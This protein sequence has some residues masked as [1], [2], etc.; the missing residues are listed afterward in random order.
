[1]TEPAVRR[2]AAATPPADALPDGPAA[3]STADSS[4]GRPQGQVP[5]PVLGVVLKG[6]PRLS[7][8]FIAQ[9]LLALQQRGFRLR[10]ISLR[11]PTDRKRH[12]IHD[13]ITAPVCYLPEYLYQ[14]ALRVLAGWRRARRLPGYRAAWRAFLKDLRRDLTPNRARR[15]GQACV[16]AAEL[17]AEVERLYAH[18]LHTPASVARYTSLMRG[19]PW[20]VSAHAK[21]IWTIPDWE[22]REKL[23]EADWL[24]TCTAYGARHLRDLA[25]EPGRVTLLYHGLDLT[26][27]AAPQDSGQEAAAPPRDGS[28]PER[29]VRLLSVG[30]LVEKKGYDDLLPALADLPEDLHWDLTHVGGG[31]LAE[32]LK[33]QAA[34]LGLGARI[35]WRG[36]LAQEEILALYRQND[37]FVLASRIA[38]SGDRDGLPNVLMEAQSQGLA[39]LATAVAAIPELIEDGVSGTLVP[40]GDPASLAGALAALIADPE[41][42]ARLGKAGQARV[43]GEFDMKRGIDTL[44]SLFRAGGA[45]TLAGSL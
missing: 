15:F 32:K 2:P 7:E 14:E 21:D 28:A 34:S 43:R 40:P 5:S 44:D 6:Y 22:K 39:C 20:S 38:R 27:F 17:P 24:V 26:R 18:F 35:T 3:Q 16:L 8:T 30:R 41:Q 45:N 10:L 19:L 9:E 33:E 4:P 13:E 23:A 1:M 42:R 11:H 29:R 36:P 12:P 31:P 37:L 25:P